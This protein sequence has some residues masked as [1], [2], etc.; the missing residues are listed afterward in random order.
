MQQSKEKGQS[1]KTCYVLKRLAASRRTQSGTSR[2]L[3]LARSLD[4]PNLGRTQI[5]RRKLDSGTR[6]CFRICLALEKWRVNRHLATQASRSIVQ[7]KRKLGELIDSILKRFCFICG[8]QFR[9]RGKMKH[10]VIQLYKTICTK[11]PL[12]QFYNENMSRVSFIGLDFNSQEVAR[13]KK[14]E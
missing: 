1:T 12:R 13:C 9:Y 11:F 4:G 5:S 6:V 2:R 3:Y 10:G 7:T 8:S 14:Y